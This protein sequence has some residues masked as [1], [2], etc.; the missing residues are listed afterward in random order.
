MSQIFLLISQLDIMFQKIS[1]LF[2]QSGSNSFVNS[3]G[4]LPIFGAE[5]NVGE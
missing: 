3:F 1:R 5:H 4:N 2:L